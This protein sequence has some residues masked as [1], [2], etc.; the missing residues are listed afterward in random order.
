VEAA[1]E[2]IIDLTQHLEDE[3]ARYPGIPQPSF[4]DIARVEHDGYAMSEYRLVNHIGTHIDAPAHL[5]Q[6][7]DTLDDI[8]LE[9]LVTDAVTLDFR[10]HA[11]GFLGLGDIASHLEQIRP[12]DL[13]F[14]CS[15]NDRNWGTEA[16]WTD[17]CYPDPEASRAIIARGISGIGFDG[18]SADPVETTTF[19]LHRI[20][21]A[22]GRLLV[23]N[24]RNLSEL[25][26][27]TR[28][29]VAPMKVRGANGAPARVFALPDVR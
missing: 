16:Y 5:I 15:G 27:R 28:V 14:I 19:E 21:L 18:P 22:A 26:A 20:W 12:G 25:P 3:M 23:E 13:L 9:R 11:K 10:D 29:V 2:M 6:D 17:W 7:G 8:G 4:A 1:V 24:L